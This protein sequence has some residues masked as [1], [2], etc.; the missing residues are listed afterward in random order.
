MVGSDR[1]L[2]FVTQVP[3]RSRRK[4]SSA[5]SKVYKGQVYCIPCYR[6]GSRNLGVYFGSFP[7][8]FKSFRTILRSFYSL[9]S[10][11]YYPSSYPLS[12]FYYRSRLCICIFH[13]YDVPSFIVLPINHARN[14]RKITGATERR[15]IV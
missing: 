5:A 1:K 4:G 6:P 14:Q 7:K 15:I 9:G 3:R 12:F 13:F 2:F 11:C 8:P 10:G